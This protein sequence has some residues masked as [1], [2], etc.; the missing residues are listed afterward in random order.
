MID[1]LKQVEPVRK[2]I[3]SR[4]AVTL[5]KIEESPHSPH[6][7]D[8]KNKSSKRKSDPSKN[9]TASPRRDSHSKEKDSNSSNSRDREN[10]KDKPRTPRKSSS[11]DGKSKMLTPEDFLKSAEPETPK[12]KVQ[13]KLNFHLLLKYFFIS[14]YLIP[15]LFGKM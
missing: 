5:E 2:D 10:R 13:K 3:E 6:K 7:K 8:S 12:P 4:R 15:V 9:E 11:K 14:P 1:F